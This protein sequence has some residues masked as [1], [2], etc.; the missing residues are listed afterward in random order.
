MGASS[1]SSSHTPQHNP[2]S[3]WHQRKRCDVA[4][5]YELLQELPRLTP[6]PAGALSAVV[7]VRHKQSGGLF[8]CKVIAKRVIITKERT[9]ANR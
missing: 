2:R 7:A 9:Q 1:S 6:G 4:Q 3:L 5:D 8:A